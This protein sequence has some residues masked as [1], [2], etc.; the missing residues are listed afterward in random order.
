MICV[1]EKTLISIGG[2]HAHS[3]FHAAN[4][5]WIA[6][7]REPQKSRLWMILRCM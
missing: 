4:R 5:E 1:S 2:M 6:L 3:H 7:S